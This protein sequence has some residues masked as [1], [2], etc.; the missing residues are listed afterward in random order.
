MIWYALFW[1]IIKRKFVI[2]L[3]FSQRLFFIT[4][5][6]AISCECVI[7]S[8]NLSGNVYPRDNHQ[9]SFVVLPLCLSLLFFFPPSLS[10][11]PSPFLFIFLPFSIYFFFICLINDILQDLKNLMQKFRHDALG[12]RILKKIE[13]H[14]LNKDCCLPVPH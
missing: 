11:R 8:E 2:Q 13:N 12:E 4:Q 10:S 1:S 7:Y 5:G 9:F 14:L 6:K 3:E